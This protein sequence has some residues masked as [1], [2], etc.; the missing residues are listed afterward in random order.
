MSYFLS[1][2]MTLFWKM[3][4]K[5]SISFSPFSPIPHEHRVMTNQQPVQAQ[6]T[7]PKLMKKVEKTIIREAKN[8]GKNLKHMVKDLGAAEKAAQKAHK[9]ETFWN[10]VEKTF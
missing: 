8:E 1:G 7:S 3:T 5:D 4:Y 9:V 2:V 6:S 10:H